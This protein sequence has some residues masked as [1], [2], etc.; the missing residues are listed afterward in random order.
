MTTVSISERLLERGSIS[1]ND[2]MLL[3]E[4]IRR[5]E[6]SKDERN[7]DQVLCSDE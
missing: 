2:L 7:S 5:E 3:R 6:L 4:E 1:E